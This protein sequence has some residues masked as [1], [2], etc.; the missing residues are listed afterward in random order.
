VIGFTPA[1]VDGM[2][3]WEFSACVEGWRRAHSDEEEMPDP[4]SNEKFDEM[5]ERHARIYH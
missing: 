3:L 1:Q 5:I 4:P 2:S